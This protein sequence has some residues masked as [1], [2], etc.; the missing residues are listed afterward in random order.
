MYASTNP[1]SKKA[2]RE[3]VNAYNAAT[4]EGGGGEPVRAFSPGPFPCPT[5]GRVALEGPHYPKAHTW[6]AN[7]EVTDG[8][9]T[10]VIS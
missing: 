7:V 6:Y 5:N 2:L 3:Q 1:K 10:K 9:V 8:I 4:S